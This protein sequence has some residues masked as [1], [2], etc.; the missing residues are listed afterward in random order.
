MIT[1]HDLDNDR[2]MNPHGF[3]E[4]ELCYAVGE[5]DEDGETA[6]RE[7]GATIICQ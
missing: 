5:D 4:T 3:E 6:E 7:V 2:R 1:Q